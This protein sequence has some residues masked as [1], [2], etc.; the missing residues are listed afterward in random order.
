MKYPC[1]LLCSQILQSAAPTKIVMPKQK[2]V[3]F[4]NLLQMNDR[5]RIFDGLVILLSR[6]PIKRTDFLI[7]ISKPF[8]CQVLFHKI[9]IA[10]DKSK[11]ASWNNLWK[12]IISSKAQIRVHFTLSDEKNPIFEKKKPICSCDFK[13][14]KHHKSVEKN[15]YESC[16]KN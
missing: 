8:S 7:K 14:K 11:L 15:Y 5:K 13:W 9:N 2:L 16:A 12:Q 10:T 6:S 4:T 3:V 1:F